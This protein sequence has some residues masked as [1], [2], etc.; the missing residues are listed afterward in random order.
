MSKVTK[1]EAAIE[2]LQVQISRYYEA[3]EQKLVKLLEEV[4]NV[5]SK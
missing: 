1:L 2:R 4:T 3:L 5:S